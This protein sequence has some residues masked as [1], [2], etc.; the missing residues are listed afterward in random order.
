MPACLLLILIC[1]ILL[2]MHMKVSA[3]KRKELSQTITSL[4]NSIRAEEGCRRCDFF[5]TME[6]ENILCLFEEWDTQ[7]HLEKHRQSECFQV[8]RGA[9]IL[10]ERPCEVISYSKS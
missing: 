2:I 8:L 7:K 9:M 4:I 6:D 5:Q 3:K 10:L 1:M